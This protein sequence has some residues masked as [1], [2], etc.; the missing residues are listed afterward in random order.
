M[1]LSDSLFADIKSVLSCIQNRISQGK[2]EHY[3]RDPRYIHASVVE[4]TNNEPVG[5]VV[6]SQWTYPKGRSSS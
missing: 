4:K 6:T 1:S 3:T 2:K 5:N